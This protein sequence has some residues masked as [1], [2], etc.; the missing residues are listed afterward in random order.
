MDMFNPDYYRLNGLGFECIDLTERYSFNV[1]N[2]RKYMVRLHGKNTAHE[3]LGKARWYARRAQAH[4]ERFRPIHET[5]MPETIGMLRTLIQHDWQH[6]SMFWASV[7]DCHTGSGD[8]TSIID[9]IN[10]LDTT[11]K[12]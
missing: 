9:A 11:E 6:A 8:T 10:E 4:G 5:D 3:N 7:L 1:G 2:C 12:E